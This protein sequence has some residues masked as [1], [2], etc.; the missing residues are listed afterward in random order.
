MEVFLRPKEIYPVPKPFS[1]FLTRFPHSRAY[2]VSQFNHILAITATFE[3]TH[4]FSI[5]ASQK[6]AIP[7]VVPVLL[8]ALAQ[9]EILQELDSPLFF[10]VEYS[11]VK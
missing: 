5:R 11:P 2:S 10:S 6:S 8:H 9:G 3:L 4:I 7:N 1:A